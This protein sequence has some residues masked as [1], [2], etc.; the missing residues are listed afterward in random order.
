MNGVWSTV[1]A[2]STTNTF[3]WN[4]T[5]LTPGTYRAQVYVRNV[6]SGVKYEA[7]LGMGY[8]VK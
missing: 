8:V 6:G 5:G 1:Q 2:Y 4:T 3:T 7:V